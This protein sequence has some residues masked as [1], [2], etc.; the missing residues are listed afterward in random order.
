[1]QAPLAERMRPQTLPEIVGQQ[2]LLAPGRTLRRMIEGGQLRNMILF[3]PPGTG[4][5]T[6]IHVIARMTR[7]EFV[8]LN[9]AAGLGVKEIRAAIARA[10]GPLI[11]H[12]DEIHRLT[13]VQSEVFLPET[14][15]GSVTLIGTTTENPYITVPPA[16]RS[17]CFVFELTRHSPDDVLTMLN[18]ALRDPAYG[19][20]QLKP[21]I[22]EDDLRRFA[23]AAGGDIRA[24]LNTLELV[25]TTTDE[26]DGV[27][28]VTL[29]ALLSCLPDG[30]G[31]FSESD[32]YDLLSALQK[33]VRGSD[34]DAAL[35][36]L[37]RWV[38]ARQDL[39]TLCRR[40]MVMAAEDIGNAYPQALSIAV[41][42]AQAAKLIGYPEAEIPL[43]QLVTLLACLP[44]SNAAYAGL[45]R[46]KADVAEGKG[47]TIP[48][49]LR[50]AHFSGAASLGRSGYLYPHDHGGWVRQQYLPDD[51]VGTIYYEPKKSGMEAQL[52]ERL[53]KLRALSR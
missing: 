26:R 47:L 40:L 29:D 49:H 45:A 41:A 31:I 6:L 38:T 2:H 8:S 21:L 53:E 33:S 48:N 46:A 16:L 18:R 27:R 35:V 34:P 23:E 42:C 25:V 24:A 9:A 3:G 11:L 43:A 12:V 20:A 39:D 28:P 36:Y 30:L 37:A 52:A 13:R 15:R 51:L 22:Q 32:E 19:I 44:K 1:M 7:H 50:D 17:R 14:E 10:K 5:T 4:K